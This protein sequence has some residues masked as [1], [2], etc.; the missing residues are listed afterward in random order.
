MGSNGQSHHCSQSTHR[1]TDPRWPA[2]GRRWIQGYRDAGNYSSFYSSTSE[3]YDPARGEWSAS[4]VL[5]NAR[6][7]HAAVF[8]QDGNVLVAGG[9]QRGEPGSTPLDSAELFGP[10][11]AVA[12][13]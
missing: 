10:T 12:P 4:A 8:L 6:G 2:V 7:E 11:D 9:S 13:G 5:N 3:L 1:H